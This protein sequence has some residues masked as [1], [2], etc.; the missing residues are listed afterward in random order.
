[1]ACTPTGSMTLL[2]ASD[3]KVRL[4][5]VSH[6]FPPKDASMS[7]IGGMQRVGIDLLK[8]LEAHPDVEVETVILRSERENEYLGFVPFLYRAF[9]TARAKMKQG[10][11]D[12]VLFSA[13]PSAVLTAVLARTSRETGVPLTAISHGHDVIADS[14]AYQWLVARVFS[15]LDAMLPVS[16][17]TGQQCV[18]RGLPPDRLFVTPNGIEPD[19]FG[20]TFPGLYSARADRR[21]VLADAF[22]ELAGL[23]GPGDLLLCSVGR[24]VK[25]KGHE[26]F[27]R[28][29]MPQL[30]ENIHLAL[31]GRGPESEV[32]RQ[33]TVD[34][35]MQSR[36]HCLGLVAEEK[37][38]SLYS[39]GDLFIMPN[40]P[41]AGDMEG[42]GVVMLEAGLCG[43][44]SIAS[45]I[46][47]I[48]DVITNG[49]NGY[50][51][52][53]LDADGFADVINRYAAVPDSLDNLSQSTRSHTV[54]TF[55][56]PGVCGQ[57]VAIL[58]KVIDRKKAPAN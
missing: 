41:I 34:T 47:G 40:I 18:Q 52:N 22:P 1:M 21:K 45:R 46:E 58:K 48:Q 19:R 42:F 29:V 14:S 6:C 54:D 2:T 56:W 17:A 15:R 44:P 5:F 43:M 20:E 50:C 7:K 33:A 24:Q 32:I 51:V 49:V 31:G 3:T 39:G 10:E 4:L 11:I 30:V 13:M 12:V 9:T 23:I 26:W 28:T 57:I 27:I 55:A 53:P 36:V 25:R 16:R 38:A 8:Q 35:G 37:L